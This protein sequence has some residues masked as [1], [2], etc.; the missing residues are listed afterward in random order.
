MNT[1]SLERPKGH[2]LG[3]YSAVYSMSWPIAQIISPLLGTQVIALLGYDAL[4]ITL[5]GIALSAS[6]GFYFMAKK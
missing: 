4:S 1:F 6:I 5:G 2:N 3:Q